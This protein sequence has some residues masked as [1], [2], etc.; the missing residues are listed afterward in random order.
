MPDAPPPMIKTLPATR[1]PPETYIKLFIKYIVFYFSQNSGS[2]QVHFSV[3]AGDI[4]VQL[5]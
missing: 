1:I 3:S 2:F 4:S 5:V